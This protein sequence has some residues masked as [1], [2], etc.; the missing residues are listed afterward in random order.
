MES[1][2]VAASWPDRDRRAT[3]GVVTGGDRGAVQGAAGPPVWLPKAGLLSLGHGRI[4]RPL[5]DVRASQMCGPCVIL[6][7]F[8]LSMRSHKKVGGAEAMISVCQTTSLNHP[9]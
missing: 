2:P 6:D 8:G 5:D 9:V 3:R 4:G 7:G 1:R